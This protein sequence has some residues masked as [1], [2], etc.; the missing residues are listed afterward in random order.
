MLVLQKKNFKKPDETQT[1]PNARIENIK[2]G[3]M[4]VSKQT[5]QPGWQWSTH[6]KSLAGT[7][8]C[9]AHYFGVWASGRMRV[10]ENNYEVLFVEYEVLFL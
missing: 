8:S 6:I 9:Q 7:G 3:D 2:I 4:A 10:R 1:P 5:Y